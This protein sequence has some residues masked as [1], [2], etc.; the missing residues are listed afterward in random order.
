MASKK[1]ALLEYSFLFDPKETWQHLSQFENAFAK[2]LKQYGMEGQIIDSIDPRG[3]RRMIF[4]RAMDPVDL[5][6][7]QPQ[8]QAA[9]QDVIKKYS[10]PKT[11]QGGK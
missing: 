9:P 7:N 5:A 8:K 6:R 1:L 10:D 11:Y 4:I 2:F 3:G